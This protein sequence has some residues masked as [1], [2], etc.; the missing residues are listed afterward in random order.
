M[1]QFPLL[2]SFSA[3]DPL[4]GKVGIH[5]F[6]T[7]HLEGGRPRGVAVDAQKPNPQANL[8]EFVTTEN[9]GGWWVVK[10]F[11]KNNP[12]RVKEENGQL[13]WKT[14]DLVRLGHLREL[15]T[16]YSKLQP[17]RALHIN[18]GIHADSKGL[19]FTDKVCGDFVEEDTNTFSV[20]KGCDRV[21]FHIVSSASP[22]HTHADFPHI[23]ILDAWCFSTTTQDFRFIQ[24]K[25]AREQ[26]V[27]EIKRGSIASGDIA[28]SF[29]KNL[30]VHSSQII[31]HTIYVPLPGLQDKIAEKLNEFS[32]CYI[33]GIG[34]MGKS[35]VALETEKEVLEL[36]KDDGESLY[37]GSVFISFRSSAEIEHF[38]NH[39][40]KMVGPQ[41]SALKEYFKQ[42]AHLAQQ[43]NKKFF[44]VI[45]NVDTDEDLERFKKIFEAL[46]PIS[47]KDSPF[48]LLIT[49][50][51]NI[52][53]YLQKNQIIPN[54][55]TIKIGE[56]CEDKEV[57]WKIFLENF[58]NSCS[59]NTK[60]KGKEYLENIKDKLCEKFQKYDFHIG[61][62]VLFANAMAKAFS[63]GSAAAFLGEVD[64]II[65][66]DNTFLKEY[67]KLEDITMRTLQA[68]DKYSGGNA[69]KV[70]QVLALL[71]EGNV[72]YSFLERVLKNYTHDEK[73]VLM[74]LP[75]IVED[76]DKGGMIVFNPMDN[77]ITMP[78]F[79]RKTILHRN[80][81]DNENSRKEI[82]RLIKVVVKE[83]KY[84]S[85]SKDVCL[86]LISLYKYYKSI[87]GRVTNPHI[88]FS[89]EE[90]VCHS[91]RGEHHTMTVSELKGIYNDFF[92]NVLINSEKFSINPV[93][94]K[95][96]KNY[97]MEE[98]VE[99]L[100]AK[101]A[102][103]L[104][105]YPDGS[106]STESAYNLNNLYVFARI[107]KLKSLGTIQEGCKRVFANC[108]EKKFDIIRKNILEEVKEEDLILF[109][110]VTFRSI[111][112]LL[113]ESPKIRFWMIK[114]SLSDKNTHA[115]LS[116]LG[117]YGI[118]R[119]LIFYLLEE[120]K[121]EE[122]DFSN[123]SL[124][125]GDLREIQELLGY[126]GKLKV[127]YLNHNSLGNSQSDSFIYFTFGL[128]RNLSL[129]KLVLSNN[130][131]GDEE[132][133]FI[134]VALKLHPN[135][136]EIELHE[137][138]FSNTGLNFLEDL[139]KKN[140]NIQKITTRYA[141][142]YSR[143]HDGTIEIVRDQNGNPKRIK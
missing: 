91:L 22:P 86:Y 94:L 118:P 96:L 128:R 24:E 92:R 99:D 61:Y 66:N 1:I 135:I 103:E 100:L 89:L 63:V 40:R 64:R 56:L 132:I 43:K 8:Q 28:E 14:V 37:M 54:E 50:R 125:M 95:Y 142:W 45:D 20:K 13:L 35:R 121:V 134:V 75:T 31:P 44:L 70:Y 77:T 85:S 76:L 30:I 34:G 141:H 52:D 117:L 47:G 2:D 73:L 126:P 17:Q 139:M 18:T 15:A 39:V 123:N 57:F 69:S 129:R 122:I 84:L 12:I 107:L 4:V 131:L 105:E 136:R 42:L 140:R 7:L 115:N 112:P 143:Y 137:N 79:Y 11:S 72:H 48:Q 114:N 111:A 138:C 49:G 38:F 29:Q 90:W 36:I 58:L 113:D 101:L 98:M 104:E 19:A 87:D 81:S 59:N 67:G 82:E 133:A 46:P 16:F 93:M 127:L 120:K 78:P 83:I 109:P 119:S 116:S 110:E 97:D 102:K 33:K 80:G 130:S 25:D 51:R 71:C 23:D 74:Q 124:G 10:G 108:R 21:S 65:L 3:Y 106:F 62:T 26:V 41:K 60:Q 9:Q 88:F 53:A 5:F 55:V 32:L 6:R 27:L 68:C